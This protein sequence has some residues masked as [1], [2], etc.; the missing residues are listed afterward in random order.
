V[1]QT[2]LP[3][4]EAP[5]PS[6]RGLDLLSTL[7]LL[8][9]INDEDRK[10]AWAVERELGTLAALVDAVA[11][12]LRAGGSLHYFGAG[13][14][15]R[16][17]VLDAA[18]IEPT[19]AAPGVICAHLAGGPAA[20]QR[21]VEGA[22][23]DEEAGRREALGCLRSADAALGISAS[24]NTP[25]VCGALRGAREA[26]ALTACL[27]NNPSGRL[28]DL[29]AVAVVLRTGPEAVAGSTRMKAASAQKMAL[30]LLSTALMVKLGKVY[31]NLMVDVVASNAKLRERAVRLTCRLAECDPD[32]ARTVLGACGYRV[33]TAVVMLRRNLDL[34]AAEQLLVTCRG[35]LRTAAGLA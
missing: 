33:K 5:N 15:G 17:G 35:D 26:G 22:E 9:R 24:G 6:T 20:Y 2:Y 30:T 28:V 4:T 23:D 34:Q 31:D 19:Y 10:A 13:T 18:E 32:T 25:Y 14:S 27:T 11:E 3:P 1:S 8:H 21:A 16:L 12:R 29:V 7:D